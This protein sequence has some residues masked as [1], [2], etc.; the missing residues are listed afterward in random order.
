MSLAVSWN[1]SHDGS[2]AE[3]AAAI[4]SQDEVRAGLTGAAVVAG[5]EPDSC[6]G[7]Q[8]DCT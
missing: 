8:A 1:S 7:I 2:P 6:W 3:R 4:S 5:T